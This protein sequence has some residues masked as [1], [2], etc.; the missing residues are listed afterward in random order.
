MAYSLDRG[1]NMGLRVDELAQPCDIRIECINALRL[2]RFTYSL[3]NRVLGA[4]DWDAISL[5]SR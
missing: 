4:V 1:E 2:R 5:Y 3:Y